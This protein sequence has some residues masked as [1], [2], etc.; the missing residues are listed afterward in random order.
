MV[1]H[2]MVASIT[3]RPIDSVPISNDKPAAYTFQEVAG[4]S[5]WGGEGSALICFNL[6]ARWLSH[7]DQAAQQPAQK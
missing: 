5:W 2:R 6:M 3:H 4:R 1:C 7:L